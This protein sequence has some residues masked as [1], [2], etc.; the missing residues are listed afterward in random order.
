MG[1]DHDAMSKSSRVLTLAAATLAIAAPAADA[2]DATP[3]SVAGQAENA[4]PAL[5]LIANDA[6]QRPWGGRR[7]CRWSAGGY[8]VCRFRRW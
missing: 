3:A 6:F 4:V 5:S 7:F 2:A 1:G 8:R